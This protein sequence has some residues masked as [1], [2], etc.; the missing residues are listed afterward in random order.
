[1]STLIYAVNNI[2]N[3]AGTYGCFLSKWKRQAQKTMNI[4]PLDLRNSPV[5]FFVSTSDVF[6]V[7][8]KSKSKSNRDR[9]NR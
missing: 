2:A 9:F 4:K 1:M 5:D 3:T 8:S 7:K 6:N